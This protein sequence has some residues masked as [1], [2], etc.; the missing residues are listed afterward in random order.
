METI[1]ENQVWNE[2]VK[3]DKARKAIVEFLEYNGG[4]LYNNLEKIIKV[5]NGRRIRKIPVYQALREV[6]LDGNIVSLN[7]IKTF[8]NEN[9]EEYKKVNALHIINEL[10]SIDN[11][12]YSGENNNRFQQFLRQ[13]ENRSLKDQV[14]LIEPYSEVLNE[15]KST[16]K[17]ANLHF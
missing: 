10:I 15:A 1:E 2:L 4:V 17:S 3:K 6:M 9:K 7:A 12:L 14:I 16:K 8:I 5:K 11:M 13:C